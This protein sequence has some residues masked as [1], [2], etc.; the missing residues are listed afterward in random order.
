[1]R[2]AGLVIVIL[3]LVAF[4]SVI[5]ER[6]AHDRS[7]MD[8]TLGHQVDCKKFTEFECIAKS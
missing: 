3:L 2:T 5:A 7:E 4:G 6:F 1:M 8:E